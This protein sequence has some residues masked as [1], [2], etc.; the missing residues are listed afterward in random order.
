MA[1]YKIICSVER[2]SGQDCRHDRSVHCDE[3]NTADSE[4]HASHGCGPRGRRID[5]NL[6]VAQQL[7]QLNVVVRADST[8]SAPCLQE[9]SDDFDT[10]FMSVVSRSMYTWGHKSV[11]FHL[12]VGK[13]PV[14]K[15]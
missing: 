10:S 1:Y 15:F 2:H 11:I 7:N 8:T 13:P 3:C 14:N 5:S 9:Y 4:R 12:F 6:V